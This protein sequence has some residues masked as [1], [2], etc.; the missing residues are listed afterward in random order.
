MDGETCK[1]ELVIEIPV[2]AVRRE[3]ESVTAQYARQARIPGF[4]PGH[5]PPSLV[6]RRFREGIRSEVVQSLLPK[7][8]ENAVKEQKW[9]VVGR[10][11]FE[12]LKFDEDQPL[13]CKA[14]FEVYPEFT[15]GEYKG[16][17]VEE[18]SPRVT[19]AD[20]DQGLEEVRQHAATFEVVENRPAQDDDYVMVNYQGHDLNSREARPLEARDAMVH[21]GAKGTVGAFTE[22]LRGTKPGE[23]REFQ[24]D[25]PDDY[26]QKSLA[27]KS[28]SY[29]VEVLSIKKKVVPAMDDELAKS[30]SEFATLPKLRDRL[31][32]DLK[33]RR[34]R[35]VEA[36]AQHKLLERLVDI[37][38]FPVPRVLVEAQLSR[39]LE[40]VL[41]QLIAQGI[42]PRATEVDWA[43]IR[44]QS[45]PE[46]EREV[47][48]SLVLEKIAE[49][50]KIEVAEEE[51]DDL[52]REM[53]QDRQET[54]AALKTRLTREGDLD[55]IATRRRNQKALDFVYR[56]AKIIR[57][58]E[59]DPARAEG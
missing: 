44:E 21:L 48:A 14:T 20:V 10:P 41:T 7:F 53:A 57:K 29:R 24:V 2:D 1:R 18:E 58:N 51:I 12:E 27:G 16:L 3:A 15:L 33:E 4:R 31:R 34:Q 5:A 47:R 50:E 49:T 13:T 38:P 6:R 30:V 36:A 37:H 19:E 55:S 11:E 32:Q 23:G 42:D 22:N 25:Y 40:R 45:R 39:K 56:N 26:P 8:F 28:F 52:I 54:P 46:A 43:K 59:P 17:E 35:E 9:T